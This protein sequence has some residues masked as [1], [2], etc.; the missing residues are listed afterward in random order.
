MS[1]TDQP[2]VWKGETLDTLGQVMSAISKIVE[3]EDS[4]E[5]EQF[6]TVY[7][8]VNPHAAENIG[9]GLGYLSHEQ[10]VKGLALFKVTHPIFG[11]STT[12]K[13]ITLE[14]AFRLGQEKGEQWTADH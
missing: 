11:G 9:Y 6:L 3:A 10:M 8:A 14:E 1:T 2:L 7:A 4:I 13:E 5:A 12:A